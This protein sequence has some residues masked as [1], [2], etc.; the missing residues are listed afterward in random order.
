[1]AT[2]IA[3]LDHRGPIVGSKIATDT[4]FSWPRLLGYW[5]VSLVVAWALGWSHVTWDS[6]T[7]TESPT[8]PAPTQS[9]S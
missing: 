9:A 4:P 1:M 8:A 3:K 2:G 5:A 7:V 6:F